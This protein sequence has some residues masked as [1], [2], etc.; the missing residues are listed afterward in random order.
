[1]N[2]GNVCCESF[3][4]LMLSSV[5]NQTAEWI[6]IIPVQ[7]IPTRPCG[8]D[9]VYLDSQPW[10]EQRPEDKRHNSCGINRIVA[11]APASLPN[12][13]TD[14]LKLPSLSKAI[15]SLSPL[16]PFIT[17]NM[18]C[19]LRLFSQIEQI[20]QYTWTWSQS[21]IAQNDSV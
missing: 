9:S 1:M 4:L 17:L 20:H 14:V 18:D 13:P 6:K 11:A 3:F 21:N 10:A 7:T 15:Q 12:M 8:F 19:F 5:C 16:C 2:L